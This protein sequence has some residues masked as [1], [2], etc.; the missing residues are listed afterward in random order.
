VILIEYF[1]KEKEIMEGISKNKMSMI[2]WEVFK[3]TEML[4]ESHFEKKEFLPKKIKFK[5]SFFKV[6][7]IKFENFQVFKQLQS[8]AFLNKL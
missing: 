7:I 4:V 1:N 6:E 8:S 5:Q 3:K 2:I